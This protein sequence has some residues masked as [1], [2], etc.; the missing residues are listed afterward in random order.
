MFDEDVIGDDHSGHDAA[1]DGGGTSEQTPFAL[2]VPPL[3]LFPPSLPP[4]AI[5][6]CTKLVFSRKRTG[7]GKVEKEKKIGEAWNMSQM[8]PHWVP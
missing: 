5:N 3:L 1:E 2:Y 7:K 6:L 8:D 4:P